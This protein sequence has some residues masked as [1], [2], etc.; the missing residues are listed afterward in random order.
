[1]HAR[2]ILQ[3]RGFRKTHPLTEAQ[4]NYYSSWYFVPIRELAGL[5]GFKEDPHWISKRVMPEITPLEAKK[6]LETLIKL[7]LLERSVEGKLVQS[8]IVVATPDEVVSSFVAEYHREMAK[9]AGE[10]IDRVQR[11]KREISSMTMG[12]SE[13]TAVKVKE[14]IQKFRQEVVDVVL[15][16]QGADTVYQLNFHLFPLARMLGKENS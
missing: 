7:G 10:S 11:D 4:Y 6:A 5:A 9:K 3:S 1:M 15:R 16:D 2:E 8:N 12:M 13:G 14:M